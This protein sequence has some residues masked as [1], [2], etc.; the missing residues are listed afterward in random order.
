MNLENYEDVERY[1]KVCHSSA[2]FDP[3]YKPNTF[4]LKFQNHSTGNDRLVG[5]I[6]QRMHQMELK[7]VKPPKVRIMTSFTVDA[8][9][10]CVNPISPNEV[11]VSFYGKK[12]L[13]L[14]NKS[15]REEDSIKLDCIYLTNLL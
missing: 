4:A 15:G 9:A 7:S 11:W 5:K 12:K 3:D 13:S 1:R 6:S 8:T 2:T 14:Y 10:R